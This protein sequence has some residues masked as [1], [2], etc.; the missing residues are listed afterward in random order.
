MSQPRDRTPAWN[1]SFSGSSSGSVSPV[2]SASS[3]APSIPRRSSSSSRSP[4][5]WAR[6]ATCT[7]STATDTILAAVAGLEVEGA[8]ARV[9]RRCR[10][11]TGRGCRRDSGVEASGVE[12]TG[13]ARGRSG[14]ATHVEADPVVAAGAVGRR[15]GTRVLLDRAG[16]VRRPDVEQRGGRASRPRRSATGPR[17]AARTRRRQRRLPPGAL[18]DRAPRPC[19][20]PRSG[21][22]ATPATWT[23]PGRDRRVDLRDVDPRLGQDR[24]LLRPAA[25]DPVGVERLERRQLDLGQPLGRRHVAVQARDDEPG[26]E[27]VGRG[28]RLVVHLH[29]DQ[30]VARPLGMP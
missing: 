27:P 21:A 4:S 18:V 24:R 10:Q 9:R 22:Q 8:V 1:A 2:T 19:D 5:R 7:F 13:T 15:R 16:A 25:R 6:T 23:G 30:R 26:R 20:T 17:S 3:S 12:G 11:R 14:D 29:G 28:Q